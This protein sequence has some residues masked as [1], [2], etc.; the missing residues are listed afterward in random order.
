[1]KNKD[2]P[3]TKSQGGGMIQDNMLFILF[4]ISARAWIQATTWGTPQNPLPR[5]MKG[6]SLDT[7]K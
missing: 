7:V 5:R 2:F 6:L 3:E 4:M 1:M